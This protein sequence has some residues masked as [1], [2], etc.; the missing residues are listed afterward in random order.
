MKYLI[1]FC[2]I[3]IAIISFGFQT[4]PKANVVRLM[5]NENTNTWRMSVNN[6][7]YISAIN[8]ATLTNKLAQ[9]RLQHGDILLLGSL[10]KGEPDP[11]AKTWKWIGRYTESNKVAVYLYGV[12]IKSLANE[13]FTVPVYHWTAPFID[14]RDM[15]AASFFCEGKYLGSGTAGFQAMRN[16]IIRK[17]PSK[18]FILG[19]LYN[20]SSSVPPEPTPY[21]GQYMELEKFLKAN[22]TSLITMDPSYPF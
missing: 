18:V 8:S 11:M 13:L 22:G 15:P 12:Y 7:G 17:H 14:P 20:M 21:E 6:T 4:I 9:L 16:A 19:S 5:L 2:L 3:I 10:Y 1:L